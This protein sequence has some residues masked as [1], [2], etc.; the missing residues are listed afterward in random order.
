VALLTTVGA[1]ALIVT[2]P[3]LASEA[4]ETSAG[5]Q[6]VATIDVGGEPR[7]PVVDPTRPRLY[8]PQ[9]DS[10]SIAAVDT[11]T[12]SVLSTVVVDRSG[13]EVDD[14]ILDAARARLFAL[15]DSTNTIVAVDTGTLTVAARFP[16]GDGY[17]EMVLDPARG[18]LYALNIES[19]VV[20]TIDTSTLRVVRT[21]KAPRNVMSMALGPKRGWLYFDGYTRAGGA[22]T[23]VDARTWRTVGRIPGVDVGGGAMT[24]DPASGRLYASIID[25]EDPGTLTVVDT[26]KRRVVGDATVGMWPGRPVLDA[27]RSRVLLA[28]ENE[29][30]VYVIDA[31]ARLVAQVRPGGYPGRPV[32]APARRSALVLAGTRREDAL[33]MI[34]LDTLQVGG[35]LVLPSGASGLAVDDTAGLAY[36]TNGD[37]GTVTVIGLP[38][39]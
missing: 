11:A 23:I 20:R 16:L 19:E 5:M 28:T 10:A 32:L 3:A 14:L 25:D 4:A 39:S 21:A 37:D 35:R 8:V 24:V 26:R 27:A 17:H 36:V 38:A 7:T 12:R 9:G 22:I 2:S 29:P 30:I 34:G 13:D 18:R 33:V 31:R 6:V 15:V 1:V